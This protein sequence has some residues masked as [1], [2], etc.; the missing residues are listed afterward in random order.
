MLV[1][2]ICDASHCSDY[3]VGGYGYWIASARGKLGG[4][5]P[6]RGDIRT[7][8]TAEMMAIVNSLHV[9]IKSSLVINGDNVIIQTDCI[10]AIQ[11]LTNLRDCGKLIPQEKVVIKKYEEYVRDAGI[12]VEFRHVKGHT[13]KRDA[14][15]ITNK[16]C[17]K[18][19]KNAMRKVRADKIKSIEMGLI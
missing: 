12:Q 9:A 10:S 6:L 4:G 13:K 17:D 11:T 19:A 2:I 1:T 3:S 15:S 8:G 7:S 16:L 5:G 18:R 14:R